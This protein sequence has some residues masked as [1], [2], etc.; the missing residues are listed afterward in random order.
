MSNSY[1]RDQVRVREEFFRSHPEKIKDRLEHL[2]E[3][4]CR[5]AFK[6]LSLVGNE[7]VLDLGAGNC[8]ASWHMATLGC[9]V[10]AFDYNLSD[11]IGLGAGKKLIKEGKTPY[12]DIVRGDWNKL[13]FKRETFDIIFCFQVLH[14]TADV[15][16]LYNLLSNIHVLLKPKG[17]LISI[18]D[19][20]A[21]LYIT[22]QERYAKKFQVISMQGGEY[23]KHYNIMQYRKAF[24]HAGFSIQRITIASTPLDFL[25]RNIFLRRLKVF[26]QLF[27]LILRRQSVTIV[28]IK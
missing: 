2:K 15:D 16:N 3:A 13:P 7:R 26:L 9:K 14:H 19:P 25:E 22:N 20:T 24:R 8:W 18:A 5:N 27:F 11:K 12:F 17:R 1:L 21:P 23:D 10:T 4:H 28:S 6:I